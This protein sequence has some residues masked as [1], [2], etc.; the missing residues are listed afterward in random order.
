MKQTENNIHLM[1]D[2]NTLCVS[3]KKRSNESLYSDLLDFVL[4]KK[5]SGVSVF[6]EK[7]KDSLSFIQG[8]AS[9]AAR[10]EICIQTTNRSISF[11]NG[12]TIY[13]L[14]FIHDGKIGIQ[15]AILPYFLVVDGNQLLRSRQF[16]KFL[17]GAFSY[18]D[19]VA[20]IMIIANSDE[21]FSF[22]KCHKLEL[23]AKCGEFI[24]MPE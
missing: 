7:D 22:E 16:L 5:E 9:E 10:K 13:C 17:N 15:G 23:L 3:S 19:H 18:K 24:N 20:S 6:V 8:L 1:F 11:Q 12:S 14:S 4:K 21:K 2:K